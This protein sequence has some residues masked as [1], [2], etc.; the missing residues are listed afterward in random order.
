MLTKNITFPPQ[1][2]VTRLSIPPP[3]SSGG[4]VAFTNMEY[5]M[6]PVVVAAP[7]PPPQESAPADSAEASPHPTPAKDGGDVP[8]PLPPKQKGA[9][10]GH[11]PLE[12][13]KA[14]PGGTCG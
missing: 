9:K 12:R 13:S 4:G 1:V 10:G 5:V 8:P 6:N 2:S 14:H 3:S 11:R 7:P